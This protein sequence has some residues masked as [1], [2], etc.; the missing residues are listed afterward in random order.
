MREY[1]MSAGRLITV[2][3]AAL[4]ISG[5]ASNSDEMPASGEYEA[6]TAKTPTY[7]CPSGYVLSCE[8]KKVGRIRFGRMGKENLDSCAC[9]LYQGMPRQSPLPG[10]Y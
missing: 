9:E 3:A 5:C 2:V 1:P 7:K 8:A 10:I 4:F 6:A